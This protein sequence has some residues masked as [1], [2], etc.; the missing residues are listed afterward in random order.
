MLIETAGPAEAPAA[1]PEAAV[2]TYKPWWATRAHALAAM[3]RDG[4][5]REAYSHAIGLSEDEAARRYLRM[6]AD[7]WR[8][9]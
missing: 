7:K 9:A 5:A 8:S 3:G 1:L 2:R 4:E 6:Q